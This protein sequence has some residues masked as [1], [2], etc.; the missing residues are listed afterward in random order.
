[1]GWTRQP[2]GT[3]L[4]VIHR[5]LDARRVMLAKRQMAHVCCRE[6]WGTMYA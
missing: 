5:Q 2:Y 6:T 1:M 4:M 3:E